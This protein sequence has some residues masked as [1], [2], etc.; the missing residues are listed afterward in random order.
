[1]QRNQKSQKNYL[2]EVKNIKKIFPGVIALDDVSLCVRSGEVHGLVGKNGAGK[3]TLIKIISGIYTPD[4]GQ[5][6]F[7][8]KEY[9]RFSPG[10]AR[11]M[12]IQL[13][14]QEQQFQPHLTVAENLFVGAWPIGKCGFVSFNE[15][16]RKA[17]EALEKLG[18][19][20]P[21]DLILSDIAQKVG[22]EVEIIWQLP[23]GKGNSSQ[24][25]GRHGREELR[26]C[27][28]VWRRL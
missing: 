11:S 15:I 27:V 25:M 13:V 3:S 1:M 4:A 28:Y 16:K 6:I 12:G 19:N 5:I 23:R 22:F 2:I 10:E 14:P 17:K 21:V 24:Q 9:E 8:G 7:N 26:K 18:I 20:I